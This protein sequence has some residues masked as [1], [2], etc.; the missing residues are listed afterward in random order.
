MLATSEFWDIMGQI[1]YVYGI[2]AGGP[3]LIVALLSML[4]RVYK[5]YIRDTRGQA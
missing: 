2:L 4:V 1:A 3:V 5:W